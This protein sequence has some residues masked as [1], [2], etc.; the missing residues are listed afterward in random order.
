MKNKF[1]ILFLIILICTLSACSSKTEAPAMRTE[2]VTA[3]ESTVVE[4]LYR[5]EELGFTFS[6][7]NSWESE[8][9]TPQV[10]N[11]VIE[12]NGKK[13]N[14]TV[15]SFAFQADKENPL[16][17]I[18]V[19]PKTWWDSASKKSDS[20]KPDYL[21]TKDSTVYCYTLPQACPYDVGAKTDLYNS[22]VLARDDVPNRFQL[23]GSET[24]KADTTK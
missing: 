15:V 9:Y 3:V 16:L 24:A 20:S 17:T 14:Y 12:E 6:I 1:C 23:L 19:V 18:M 13:I 21:G 8:N 2:K 7:P 4:K 10:T 5:N 11:N 22:M